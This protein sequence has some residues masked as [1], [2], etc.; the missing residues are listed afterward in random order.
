MRPILYTT[1][2]PRVQK[3]TGG[4]QHR[5]GPLP[6]V[7]NATVVTYAPLHTCLVVRPTSLPRIGIYV[8][9][10]PACLSVVHRTPSCP[11][12]TQ[13]PSG[14][15][16]LAVLACPVVD[17]FS[18]GRPPLLSVYK[19]EMVWVVVTK[20]AL[21]SESTESA[22]PVRTAAVQISTPLLIAARTRCWSG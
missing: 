18:M 13:L 14:C 15:P 19:R 4:V 9:S 20:R 8:E 17:K 11:F 10:V 21:C 5:T 16:L 22:P 3:P 6:L 1:L 7:S 2:W 12:P